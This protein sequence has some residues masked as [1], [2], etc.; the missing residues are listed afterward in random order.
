[1]GYGEIWDM[2]KW[3]LWGNAIWEI[4]EMGNGKYGELG[5]T[6]FS[7]HSTSDPLVSPGLSKWR[8]DIYR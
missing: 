8:Y 6:F 4:W 5:S 7:N 3:E 1:M 2:G